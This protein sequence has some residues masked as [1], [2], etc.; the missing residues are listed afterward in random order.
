MRTYNIVAADGTVLST[1]RNLAGIRRAARKYN[2]G[3][4]TMNILNNGRGELRIGFSGNVLNGRYMWATFT[5]EFESFEVLCDF[6]RRWKSV[7][8]VGLTLCGMERG[9]VGY[10]EAQY[11]LKNCS[12]TSEAS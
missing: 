10:S 3:R 4:V 11:W 8:H 2:V 6:V 12:F 1:S 5:T 7:Y 9:Q